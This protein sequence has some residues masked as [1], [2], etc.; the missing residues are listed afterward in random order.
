MMLSGGIFDY[1]IAFLSGVAVSFTPCVYPVI[2][3]MAAVIGRLNAQHKAWQGL[4]LSALF[5]LGMSCVYCGL[6]VIAALT[7]KLFGQFQ[8]TPVIYAGVGVIIFLFG[9]E[10]LEVIRWPGLVWAGQKDAPGKATAAGVFCAGLTAGFIMGPCTAPVLGSLLLFVASRQNIVY[11]V[12]LML[13]F[14]YGAG[15]LLILIGA[16]SGLLSKLPKAGKW[17]DS[18]KKYCGWVLLFLAVYFLLKAVR[19]WIVQ[20]PGYFSAL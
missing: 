2:P 1:A 16:F 8:N 12:V 7:G 6:A 11:G 20:H 17:M 13:I 19:L 9:L 18:V 4:L 14:A 15:A 10:M 3:V 5:V